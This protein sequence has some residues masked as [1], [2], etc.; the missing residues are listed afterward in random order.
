MAR[1]QYAIARN[2]DVVEQQGSAVGLDQMTGQL[3]LTFGVEQM[4]NGF[5][6]LIAVIGL[7]LIGVVYVGLVALVL[8]GGLLLPRCAQVQVVLH[9][10]TL[11]L[12]SPAGDELFKLVGGQPGRL[13]ELR[14]RRDADPRQRLGFEQ[15]V[16]LLS[17]SLLPA[18]IGR[19]V[20]GRVVDL[21]IARVDDGTHG[22][23]DREREALDQ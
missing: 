1:A 5:D 14:V 19:F 10:L 8:P 12:P 4:L 21:V 13:G 15:A 2:A 17:D 22:R 6:F 9:H 16:A 7:S 11:H 3:R 20:D 23:V 18:R